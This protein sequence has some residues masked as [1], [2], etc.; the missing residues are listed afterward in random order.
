MEEHFSFGIEEEYF[1]VDA[2]TKAVI[3]DMPKGFLAA[4]KKA[5][6]QAGGQVTSEMLQAQIEVATAPHTEMKA[7]RKELRDLRRTLADVAAA[8]PLLTAV[9]S[10]GAPPRVAP[11]FSLPMMRCATSH[12]A[13]IALTISC[14]PTTTS[15]SRHSSCAVTPG[16][17]RAGS[18]ARCGSKRISF[19]SSATRCCPRSRR[20]TFSN[21]AFTE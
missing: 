19:P 8:G 3:C 16:S 7:A 18:A 2:E 13:S 12:T 20:D 14:L 4:A 9:P 21:T 5:A 6:G 15:S 17:T 10:K 11:S 1:L